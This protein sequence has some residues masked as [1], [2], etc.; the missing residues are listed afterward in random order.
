MYNFII[1]SNIVIFIMK[2]SLKKWDKQI[3]EK[4]IINI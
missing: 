1:Q 2:I 3:S 4:F